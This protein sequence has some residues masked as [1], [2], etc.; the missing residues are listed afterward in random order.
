[1][2]ENDGK[3]TLDP[4][5]ASNSNTGFSDQLRQAVRN[6]GIVGMGGA[7]FPAHVNFLLQRQAN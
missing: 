4:A 1:M 6:A 3:E 7:A 2:I 5:I